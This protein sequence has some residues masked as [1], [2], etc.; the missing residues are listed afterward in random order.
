[1]A[2][3]RVQFSKIF[4]G[5]T[6]P[7]TPLYDSCIRGWQSA[8]FSNDLVLNVQLKKNFMPRK[9][10]WWYQVWMKQ[11]FEHQQEPMIGSWHQ[12]IQNETKSIGDQKC[13]WIMNLNS[14]RNHESLR[15]K[16][17]ESWVISRFKWFHFY[18]RPWLIW[19]PLYCSAL[20]NC[21]F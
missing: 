21:F 11:K 16:R 18:P 17:R 6:C 2:F 12:R 1:M 8:C 13:S 9:N 7:R 15:K 19:F 5:G 4:S 20:L 10:E 3:T 14:C